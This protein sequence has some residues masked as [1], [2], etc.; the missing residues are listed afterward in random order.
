MAADSNKEIIDK[1]KQVSYF[2][3]Y[4]KDDTVMSKIAKMCKVKTFNSGKTLIEEGE[5]GDELF[6]ILNGEIDIL[7][8]W[9]GIIKDLI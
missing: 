5:Y 3:M 1:L 2:S 4:E 9:Y 6:I 8:K 7:K